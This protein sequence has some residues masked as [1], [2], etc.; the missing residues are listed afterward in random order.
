MSEILVAVHDADSDIAEIDHL[1]GL[2]RAELLALDVEDVTRARSEAAAPA[3]SRGIDMAAVGAL[4]VTLTPTAKVLGV[5]V[6]TIRA[7][8]QRAPSGRTVEISVGDA[9]L[10]VSHA[11][12]QQQSRLIEEFVRAAARE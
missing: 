9:T 5:L 6:S 11:S 8:L 4:V 7:W 10:K 12:G 3:G 2:L 1:V